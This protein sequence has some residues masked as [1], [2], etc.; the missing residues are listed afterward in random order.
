MDD[1]ILIFE[2]K[3]YKDEVSMRKVIPEKVW[4][5]HTEYHM[6]DQWILK[7]FDIEKQVDRN[8]AINDII[9]FIDDDM[10]NKKFIIKVNVCG[11]GYYL[12]KAENKKEAFIKMLKYRYFNC[13]FKQTNRCY[14]YGDKY[15]ITEL[16]NDMYEYGVYYF[17][18]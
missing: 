13:G 14:E 3:N 17:I 11:G 18:H 2:Y 12:I 15:P 4:F 5:G 6:D 9:K 8:F 16:S 1:N 10:S 7:A